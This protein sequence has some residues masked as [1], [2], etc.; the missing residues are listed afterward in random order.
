MKRLPAAFAIVLSILGNTAL[1]DVAGMRPNVVFILADDLGWSDLGSYGND[2]HQTPHLDQL[3]EAGMR[4]TSAYAASSVCSPTRA[5]IL[6]GKYPARI[7]L[8]MWLTGHSP[9]DAKLLDAPFARHLP[10]PEVTLA[11]ALLEAGY[12]TASIGKWHLGREHHSPRCT[13]FELKIA[14]G[15]AGYPRGGYFLPNKM[16]LPGAK[17][18]EHL[19]DRLTDEAL[20][21]IDANRATPFFLYLPYYAVHAP[22]EGKPELVELY[23]RRMEQTGEKFRPAYA[24]MIHGLD[25]N[26]GRILRRLDELQL[27]DR[28]L[29]IFFSDNGG[30]DVVTSNAPLRAGKGY[31]YEGGHREPL[32]VRLPGIVQPAAV[33]DQPVISTD[34]YPTI[35]DAVGLSLKTDQHVDGVSLLPLLKDPASKLD[36]DALYWHFPHYA[37]PGGT[38][39]G[40]IRVG[41]FKLIEFFE[42][43]KLELYDLGEDVG[44][45]NDLAGRM[46]EKVK[47]LHERLIAWRKQVDAKLPPPNPN[48]VRATP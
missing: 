5:S 28:T 36:R 20:E 23:T 8:T 17:K 6:T 22:L 13:G 15:V 42:D 39:S 18:G 7:D 21:F 10:D 37:P 24:A 30:Y 4:F 40:A 16:K 45:T 11:E 2:V 19:T 31:S 38:P 14:G 35:L 43:G 9:P 27:T 46:P 48:W 33:S 26:V 1:A 41:D 29:V 34:F 44:E 3:A 12:A 25:E 32:I 47:E